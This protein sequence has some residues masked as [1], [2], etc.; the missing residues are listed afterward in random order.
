LTTLKPHSLRIHPEDDEIAIF[1]LATGEEIRIAFAEEMGQLGMKLSVHASKM[2]VVAP[3]SGNAVELKTPK[4]LIALE[5][6]CMAIA[7]NR[8]AETPKRK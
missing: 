5:E 6:G 2:L 1:T 4:S 3:R 8:R 7:A